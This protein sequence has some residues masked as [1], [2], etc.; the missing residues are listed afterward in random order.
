MI[1]R[2]LGQGQWVLEPD[3]LL[4]L[5]DL[6]QAIEQAVGGDDQAALA[7]ALADLGQRVRERGVRVPDDVIAESD[8]VLPDED[9]T[10]AEV[11]ALLEAQSDYYGLIPDD[12][13]GFENGP[14]QEAR[15]D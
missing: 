13:S 2:I 7:V 11:A 5:N 3:E 6:D 1:V 14:S 4:A 8:L 15:I 10:V 12:A 9:A